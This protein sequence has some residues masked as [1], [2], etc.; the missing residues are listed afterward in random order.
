MGT[1]AAFH[2]VDEYM[3]HAVAFFD[4]LDIRFKRKHQRRVF[5]ASD[6]SSVIPEARNKC[7][8]LEFECHIAIDL[9]QCMRILELLVIRAPVMRL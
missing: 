3:A 2:S 9:M 5:I 4:E 8:F 7:D 1:E 6:E